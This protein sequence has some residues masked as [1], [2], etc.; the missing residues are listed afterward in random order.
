MIEIFKTN[1]T[2]HSIAVKISELICLYFGGHSAS[3]DLEDC[4]KV[5]RVQSD[6][7]LVP[8]QTIIRL[9]QRMGFC[10]EILTDEKPS[11]V[12]MM[13]HETKYYPVME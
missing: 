9:L 7:G 6:H 1:V 13:L 2:N 11:V 10:A 8:S 5:L 3:F 12:D 4:D